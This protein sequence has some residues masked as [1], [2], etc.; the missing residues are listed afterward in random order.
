VFATNPRYRSLTNGGRKE[1]PDST[2]QPT[3]EQPASRHTGKEIVPQK[4]TVLP[5]KAG[6]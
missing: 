6:T 5:H 2:G 3:G 4:I 1:S